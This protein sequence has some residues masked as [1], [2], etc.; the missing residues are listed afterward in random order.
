MLFDQHRK[1]D[2]VQVLQEAKR[3]RAD[4]VEI[5]LELQHGRAKL[6]D[7]VS[8]LCQARLKDQQRATAFHHCRRLDAHDHG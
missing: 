1:A 4:A 8:S 3:I 6:A 2:R 5:R 7:A